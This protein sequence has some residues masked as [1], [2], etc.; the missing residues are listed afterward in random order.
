MRNLGASD[1]ITSVVAEEVVKGLTP[2]ELSA[3]L[4]LAAVADG[5]ALAVKL[6]TMTE[7]EGEAFFF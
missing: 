5:S 1:K 6:A 4:L 2:D 3:A 7:A